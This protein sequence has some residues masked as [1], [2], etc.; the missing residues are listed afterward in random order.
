ML[1][2]ANTATEHEMRYTTISTLSFFLLVGCKQSLP[3]TSVSAEKRKIDSY[4]QTL[5]DRQRLTGLTISATRNDSVVYAQ[6]FGVTNITT[7]AA[8]KPTHFFHWASVSKTFVATAIM[9]LVERGKIK[10]DV[11][12][13]T[14]IPFFR[15]DV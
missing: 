9:Q 7:R 1:I 13:I 15:F 11:K 14:Y 2:K 6:A 12:F 4:V 8:M 3:E 10:L 5:V